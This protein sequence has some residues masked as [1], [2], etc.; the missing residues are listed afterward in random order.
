MFV[1]EYLWESSVLHSATIAAALVSSTRLTLPYQINN[2]QPS[3]SSGNPNDQG[4]S[5]TSTRSCT[6]SAATFNYATA[7]PRKYHGIGIKKIK[8][9][10]FDAD[11][12]V[13]PVL[14]YFR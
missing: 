2:S 5:N 11:S 12:V 14:I 4:I 6:A 1:I 10:N 8:K 7:A 3:A 9:T 13:S